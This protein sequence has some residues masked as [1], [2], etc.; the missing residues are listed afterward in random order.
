MTCKQT[1]ALH[2]CLELNVNTRADHAHMKGGQTTPPLSQPHP[3]GP[4][5]WN[6]GYVALLLHSSQLGPDGWTHHRPDS[7][8]DGSRR[9]QTPYRGHRPTQSEPE[10]GYYKL[11]RSKT[12]Q[13]KSMDQIQHARHE[14]VSKIF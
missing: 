11:N 8:Q 9:Q 6:C 10:G 2:R 12:F 5:H 1:T 3:E 7:H 4:K 13:S 14:V